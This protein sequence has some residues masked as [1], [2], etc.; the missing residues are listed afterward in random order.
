M[1]PE[2]GTPDFPP[3]VVPPEVVPPEVVPP[4][5]VPPEVVPP[6]VMPPELPAEGPPGDVTQ[7]PLTQAE[8]IL[9]NATAPT[10]NIIW[11]RIEFFIFDFLFLLSLK[12]REIPRHRERSL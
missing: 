5:V 11:V 6:E 10:A 2:Y 4:E 8:R 3:E 1:A 9:V 7:P 12:L